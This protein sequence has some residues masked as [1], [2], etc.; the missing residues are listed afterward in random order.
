MVCSELCFSKYYS[1]KRLYGLRQPFSPTLLFYINAAAPFST[2][3]TVRLLTQYK[4]KNGKVRQEMPSSALRLSQR[5]VKKHKPPN[6]AL[7]LALHACTGRHLL[8]S[9]SA[10][11]YK[12]E[13][14]GRKK[15][16]APLVYLCS[17]QPCA[18][19]REG[20]AAYSRTGEGRF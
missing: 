1:I 6:A 18:Y 2:P 9:T 11:V 5:M 4:R 10:A 15:E 12:V 14:K 16:K 8:A 19:T 13:P 3:C 7:V 20:W 17:A